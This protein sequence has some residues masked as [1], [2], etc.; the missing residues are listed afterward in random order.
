MVRF[1]KNKKVENIFKWT[2][3][4]WVVVYACALFYLYYGQTLYFKT[5]RF[6]SDLA[7][8][9]KFAVEDKFF[10][11]FTTF[12][13]LLLYKLPAF[14]YTVAFLLMATTIGSIFLTAI[15]LRKLFE[16]NKVVVSKTYIDFLALVSNFVIGFYLSFAG[17]SHY[18]AYQSGNLWH[19]STYIFMRFFAL[20][21]VLI[22]IKYHEN[23]KNG[24]D[25]KLWFLLSIVLMITTGIKASFFTVFG[26]VMALVLLYD[27][28][29]KTK[30]IRVFV[31][32]LTVIPSFAVVL[33][34]NLVLFGN[35]TGNGFV[36]NPFYT[37][38][39]RGEHPKVTLILSILFPL[40]VGICHTN[41]IWKNKYY[42]VSILIFIFGFVEV[43]LFAESG[44]R[45]KD[46]NFLWGYAISIFFIFVMS[47]VLFVK[48][49]LNM[50]KDLKSGSILK[51]VKCLWL[52][53]TFLALIWHFISGV[54]YF[55]LLLSGVTY[56]V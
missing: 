36:I 26:P 52:V 53:L 3:M 47:I 34:Q 39:L 29:T 25:L 27:L 6:E 5:G 18:V 48:D 56:F 46:G 7:F 24:I 15:L 42:T 16:A 40:M 8:H 13:Y 21:T 12:L 11:S 23:Y 49:F 37:L 1:F 17:K 31:A 22:F 33:Y 19:N 51:K 45:S 28:C 54:W 50:G 20:L 43:F 2:T 55:V 4:I 35:D 38:S 10:Y 44:S 30:F 14:N 9:L 41:D 32:A